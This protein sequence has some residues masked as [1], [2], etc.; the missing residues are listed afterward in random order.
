MTVSAESQN[1]LLLY[2]HVG[3]GFYAQGEVGIQSQF[4]IWNVPPAPFTEQFTLSP[5]I[6]NTI[7]V[8]NHIVYECWLNSEF[9]I[10]FCWSAL[11]FLKINV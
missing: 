8:R 11:L 5:L 9:Q 2:L 6:C 1:V 7:F 4:F 10:V 3:I